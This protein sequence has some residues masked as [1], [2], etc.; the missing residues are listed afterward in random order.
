MMTFQ[1]S[2]TWKEDKRAHL[3]ARDNPILQVGT[4]LEFGGP[5]RTWCPEELFVASIGSCVMSTF[6]YF[7]ERFHLSLAAYSSQAKGTL[8]K[9]AEGL[10]FSGVDVRITVAWED[11][12]SLEKARSL[13][14]KEKLHKYCPVSASLQCPVSIRMEMRGHPAQ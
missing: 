11:D 10:R 4:P 1:T 2:L 3:N 13:R 12:K 14:L 7:A 9:T 8:E 6:L 5:A